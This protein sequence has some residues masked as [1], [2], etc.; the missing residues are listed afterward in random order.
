M[1]VAAASS[2]IGWQEMAGGKPSVQTSTT[3]EF[4]QK[5]Q[6]KVQFRCVCLFKTPSSL[7]GF[8]LSFLGQNG[9]HRSQ[10]RSGGSFRQTGKVSG[11]GCSPRLCG[12]SYLWRLTSGCSDLMAGRLVVGW[13]TRHLTYFAKI[14]QGRRFVMYDLGGPQASK[15]AV[16]SEVQELVY[17]CDT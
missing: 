11:V 6:Q 12:A 10:R 7:V 17:S 5:P 14:S 13:P 3:R 8:A 9:L 2:V 1:Y 4:V 16:S 15:R